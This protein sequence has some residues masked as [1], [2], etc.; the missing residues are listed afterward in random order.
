MRKYSNN[1]SKKFNFVN[2]EGKVNYSIDAERKIMY[3]IAEMG[4]IPIYNKGKCHS[5][6]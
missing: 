4:N 6:I 5:L 1:R 3:F 2:K